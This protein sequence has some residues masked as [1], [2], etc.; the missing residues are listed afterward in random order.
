MKPYD[1]VKFM[2]KNGS[3]RCYV[4]FDKDSKCVK[5]SSDDMLKDL[6]IFCEND[7]VDY[8][9]HE[10]F[11]LEI[12]KRSGALLGAFVWRTNRGQAVCRKTFNV[13]LSC[14]EKLSFA[15]SCFEA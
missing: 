14:K 12:G 8:K 7:K 1:F 6:R 15:L 11:F 9:N 3:K 4:V 10:G 2:K 5:T 13:F